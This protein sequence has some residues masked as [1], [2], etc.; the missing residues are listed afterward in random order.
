MMIRRVL[1]VIMMSQSDH[2]D[3]GN[4]DGGVQWQLL[5]SPILILGRRATSFLYSWLTAS[6]WLNITSQPGPAWILKRIMMIQS[7]WWLAS[8]PPNRVSVAFHWKQFRPVWSALV[9][10]GALLQNKSFVIVVIRVL[11]RRY[12]FVIKERR[13]QRNLLPTLGSEPIWQEDQLIVFT[14]NFKSRW[15]LS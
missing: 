13:R 2:R 4:H 7:K 14:W 1:I 15:V 11:T 6:P 3:D 9:Y 12:I 8:K 10:D 5:T